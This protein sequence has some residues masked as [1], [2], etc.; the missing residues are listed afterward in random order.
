[1]QCILDFSAG[2]VFSATDHDVLGAVLDDNKTVLVQVTDVTGVEPAVT[3]H[4]GGFLGTVPVAFHYC[5]ALDADFT[6]LAIGQNIAV[7]VLDTNFGDRLGRA[8]G[9]FRFG[10]IKCAGNGSADGIGFSQ[11][12]TQA[13]LHDT[14]EFFLHQCQVSR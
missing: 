8:T 14:V 3:Q 1:G 13:W 2:Y 7:F 11:A 6:N 4:S 5:S 10:E 12:I 9:A